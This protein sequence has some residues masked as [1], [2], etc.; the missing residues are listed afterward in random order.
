MT[1]DS[2]HKVMT[3]ESTLDKEMQIGEISHRK[4]GDWKKVA[5]GKWVPV[6]AAGGAKAAGE[7]KSFEGSGNMAGHKWEA[8]K[9][10]DK[11]VVT[12]TYPDGRT[13]KTD[14]SKQEY[15]TMKTNARAQKPEA[16]SKMEMSITDW[17]DKNK[18]KGH[19]APK[20]NMTFNELYEGMKQGKDVDKMLGIT[21]SETRF[22]ILDELAK[23][24]GKSSD[25]IQ[26]LWYKNYMADEQKPEVPEAIAP[27]VRHYTEN[28]EKI[29][30]KVESVN[31]QKAA[32]DLYGSIKAFLEPI[33]NSLESPDVLEEDKA[34]LRP[35]KER[36]EKAKKKLLDRGE[37]AMSGINPKIAKAEPPKAEG[38]TP[39]QLT[40]KAN[41]VYKN[42]LAEGEEETYY[43]ESNPDGAKKMLR[44]AFNLSEKEADDL[45][46]E[47]GIMHGI[48][49]WREDYE[50]EQE[51]ERREVAYN[52]ERYGVNELD[53]DAAPKK[54]TSDT[55]VRLSKIKR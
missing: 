29:E 32:A 22:R 46:H 5:P 53:N 52:N 11:F 51:T 2:L 33:N 17:T 13:D 48:N 25:E 3:G 43:S 12:H 10:G 45:Y 55:K 40:P 41:E 54:L 30:Q 15:D 28:V 20:N 23:R 21:E 36:L 35:L 9:V 37:K 19:Y 39:R 50:R 4:A 14:I 27:L 42:L 26:D 34:P 8:E 24:T 1:L 49:K 6:K 16:T 31:N 44:D 47:L 18:L 38:N 7:K